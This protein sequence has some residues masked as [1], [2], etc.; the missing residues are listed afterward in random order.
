LQIAGSRQNTKEDIFSQQSV[1]VRQFK[2][3]E[4]TG[5]TQKPAVNEKKQEINKINAV[6]SEKKMP[7]KAEQKEADINK[8]QLKEKLTN[9]LYERFP[10]IAMGI[11]Q[12]EF[13]IEN[14]TIDIYVDE[15]VYSLINEDIKYKE[16]IT[17]N[18]KEMISSQDYMV[19]ITVRDD[20][21]K[22]AKEAFG[23][24]L[25]FEE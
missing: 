12:A 19:S 14:K 3:N 25:K 11:K 2:D 17:N 20:I 10:L 24:I 15:Y 1:Q 7:R 18:I 16:Y 6:K 23:D 8:Q 22:Q 5:F 21:K 4:Q 13:V 9:K